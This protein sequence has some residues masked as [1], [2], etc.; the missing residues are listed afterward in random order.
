[1]TAII[2]FLDNK[3]CVTEPFADDSRKCVRLFLAIYKFPL[4]TNSLLGPKAKSISKSKLPLKAASLFTIGNKEPT[5]AE[6]IISLRY[7]YSF[8]SSNR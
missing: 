8:G 2:S 5:P 7:P 4:S 1:M 3:K 6:T